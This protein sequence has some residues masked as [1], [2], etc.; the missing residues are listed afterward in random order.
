MKKL[1][2]GALV[3]CVI[4]AGSVAPALANHVDE[5][6]HYIND[7][8]GV[9]NVINLEHQEFIQGR[10]TGVRNGQVF[11]QLA[12]GSMAEVPHMA[13]F[14]GTAPREPMSSVAVGDDVLVMLPEDYTLRVVNPNDSN[15]MV[16]GTYEGIYRLPAAT[17]TAWEM[18]MDDMVAEW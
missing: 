15:M 12:D 1:F 4:L 6:G 7:P 2:L 10:V 17:V 3:S 11:M 14:W 5:H 8:A 9:H 16:L 18:D 13:I